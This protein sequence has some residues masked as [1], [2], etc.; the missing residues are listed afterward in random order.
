ML[1]KNPLAA[2]FAG[3]AKSSAVRWDSADSSEPNDMQ[4]VTLSVMVPAPAKQT[5]SSSQPAP[6]ACSTETPCPPAAAEAALVGARR[7]LASADSEIQLLSAALVER[8]SELAA[9]RR[10]LADAAQERARLEA[11]CAEAEAEA[12]RL[13]GVLELRAREL[14]NCDRVIGELVA[15]RAPACARAA[16]ARAAADAAAAYAAR[17]ERVA[18]GYERG[19]MEQRAARKCAEE[20]CVQLESALAAKCAQLAFIDGEMSVTQVALKH[21]CARPAAK[22]AG[23]G[24]GRGLLI[25]AVRRCSRSEQEELVLEAVVDAAV[26]AC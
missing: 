11:A 20:R 25:A 10:Q 18:A 24:G 19:F 16:D 26:A 9:Q 22:W 14:A 4:H 17:L 23:G 21:A 15:S 6:A 1:E 8:N 13:R 12:A 7:R 3:A 2:C 5:I